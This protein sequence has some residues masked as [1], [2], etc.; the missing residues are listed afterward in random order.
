MRT[1]AS[2]KIMQA[3]EFGKAIKTKGEERCVRFCVDSALAHS[4]FFLDLLP[5]PLF[6][7]L[8]ARLNSSGPARAND[9]GVGEALGAKWR[10]FLFFNLFFFSSQPNMRALLVLFFVISAF[11]SSHSEAPGT[12]SSPR[13]DITDFY[14]FNSY[15][16]GRENFVTMLMNVNGLQDTFAGP[17]YFPLPSDF[18]FQFHIDNTGDAVEDKTFQF[19]PGANFSGPFDASRGTGGGLAIPVPLAGGRLVKVALANIGQ[20]SASDES[21]LNYKEHYQLRVFNGKASDNREID[22]GPFATSV[23]NNT[24]YL[25]KPFDNA[26]TKTF[27]TGY[28][29]YSNTFIHTINIPGCSIPG[30][31]FVG[32]RSDPFNINLGKVFDLVNLVPAEELGATQSDA[33]NTLQRKAITTFALEVAKECLVGPS[34]NGVIGGWASVSYLKHVGVTHRH[35][36]GAQKNRLGNPLINE[37]FIGL[38]DKDGWNYQHPSQEAKFQEYYDYPTLP[39]IIEI[40]FGNLVRSLVPSITTSLAP[41]VYP[42]LDL[43]VVL[44][45]GVPGVTAQTLVGSG[46]C[47]TISQPPLADILRLNTGIA[48]TPRANQS[49]FGVVGGDNAGYPNGRRPGDDLVDIFLRVG[50][51][52][53][54][55]PPYDTAF[56]ICNATQAPIGNLKLTD[57]APTSAT[58]LQNQFP[59]LNAPY[60]GSLLPS[61]PLPAANS[62]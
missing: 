59:Y 23:V 8:C 33:N 56:M 37:L 5:F 6:F 34:P 36:A 12:A 31:V 9:V 39:E 29:A 11:S 2:F 54:C 51:G 38:V 55:H 25:R 15:E 50:M 35:V 13:S 48:A 45:L 27:P 60:P 30:R 14:L 47:G 19:I 1:F 18:V 42:R 57:G 52:R 62:F 46:A 43:R 17:N 4:S 32:Q 28:N 24:R 49:S 22:N 21:S 53:L 10:L 16:P 61:D 40:L 7:L 44:L 20:V 58:A 41:A 3:K 26:G